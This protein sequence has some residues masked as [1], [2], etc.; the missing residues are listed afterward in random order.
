M[1]ARISTWH[2]WPEDLERW[3]AR[4]SEVAKPNVQQQPGLAAAY[5]LV[6]REGGR[7]QLVPLP[8][9]NPVCFRVDSSVFAPD[10]P[11]EKPRSVCL[12]GCA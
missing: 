5:W 3:V 6:D 8:Y 1:F 9:H 7:P 12:S 4:A 10:K 2:G 11:G